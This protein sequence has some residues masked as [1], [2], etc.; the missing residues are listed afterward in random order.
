[1]KKFNSPQ[2]VMICYSPSI[3]GA[4][5]LAM[6]MYQLCVENN[7][8]CEIK[9]LSDSISEMSDNLL[10]Q[11]SN[12]DLLICV[13]GDGS[14]LHASAYASSMQIPILGVRM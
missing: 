10:K 7:L 1:M 4:E 13:G 3:E 9:P 5:E 2:S 12:S 6:D 8:R 11:L 14:V